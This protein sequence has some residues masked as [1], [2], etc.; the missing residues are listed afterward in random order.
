L[1]HIGHVDLGLHT[2]SFR[3]LSEYVTSALARTIPAWKSIVGRVPE[4]VRASATWRATR[5]RVKPTGFALSSSVVEMIGMIHE[6][7]RGVAAAEVGS[8]VHD[9]GI[10]KEER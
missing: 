10:G 8:A 9:G 6:Q 1:K 4:R 7:E 5:G 3:E 2:E